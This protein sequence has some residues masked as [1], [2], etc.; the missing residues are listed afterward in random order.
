MTRWYQNAVI[1]GTAMPMS[2]RGDTSQERWTEILAPLI[3][4]EG[5]GRLFVELGCN[6]GYYLRQARDLGYRAIG[7][8]RD[9]VFYEQACYWEGQ[10]SKGVELVC[11]DM[12]H[13]D[14]PANYLTLLACVH[15]WLTA[16]QLKTLLAK[17][18]HRS[19]NLVIMGKH[20]GEAAIPPDRRNLLPYLSGWKIA[21]QTR[22]RR[23][24]GLL[25]H[26]PDLYEADVEQIY[27][28]DVLAVAETGGHS[29]FFPAFSEFVRLVAGNQEFD[30]RSTEFYRYLRRR[31]LRYRETL[32]EA[33]AGHVLSIRAGGIRRP[34]AVRQNGLVCD[35][36]HRLVIAKELGIE[37]IICRKR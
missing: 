3:S 10:E 11:D 22:N 32:M 19:V 33:Y 1:E 23:H 30:Y 12:L 34:I 6:A 21:T 20:K 28:R 14:T 16:E 31:K 17:L 25:L 4:P 15:Y 9:P 36:N 37:K 13:Y 2:R 27:N 7:V 26:N 18:H 8:E 5:G 24:Y 35:G 29:D